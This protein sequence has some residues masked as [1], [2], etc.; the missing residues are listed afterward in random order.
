MIIHFLLFHLFTFSPFHFHET[1]AKVRKKIRTYAYLFTF[2]PFYLKK[3]VLRCRRWG[4]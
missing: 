3:A 4:P 2:L 1:G